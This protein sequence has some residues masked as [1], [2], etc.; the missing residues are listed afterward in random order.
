MATR[1]VSMDDY[2]THNVLKL[3][4]R[5]SLFGHNITINIEAHAWDT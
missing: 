4:A 2:K 5:G 3:V 1:Q